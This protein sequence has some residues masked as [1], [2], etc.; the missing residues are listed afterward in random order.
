M[1]VIALI[2]CMLPPFASAQG[3][4]GGDTVAPIILKGTTGGSDPLDVQ[5][6]WFSK[7]IGSENNFAIIFKD[8]SGEDL[9]DVTFDFLIL[10]D[11]EELTKSSFAE[12]APAGQAFG[13]HYSFA[14]AGSYVIRIDNINGSDE[15]VE[16]PVQVTPEFPVLVA[17]AAAA[18]IGVAVA[19]SRLGLCFAG[20]K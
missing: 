14:N 9:E 17:A 20:F 1:S 19:A 3:Q 16:F 2:A 10:R 8:E 11:G 15:S 12:P 6:N 18:M 5:I 13:A 7:E 4:L